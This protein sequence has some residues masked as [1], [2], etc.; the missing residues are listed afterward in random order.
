MLA[1]LINALSVVGKTFAKV[2]IALI[3][4]GAANFANYTLLKSAGVD[5][6]SI[7]A[8]DSKGTLHRDRKDIAARQQELC[9]KWQVCLESN[10][11]RIT[12]GTEDALR[13]TDIALAFSKPGPGIIR[14]EWVKGMNRQAI[15]FA[16]ANPTPEIW[17]DDAKAAGAR[18]VATGR[19]DFPNQ[20]NNG[21][22]FPGLFRGVL[23]VRAREIN[24]AMTI[25]VAQSLAAALP[26]HT[27]SADRILPRIDDEN[28]AIEVA[29]AAGLSAQ[30]AGLSRIA[31][32]ADELG[33][34]AREMIFGAR[35]STRLLVDSGLI[36]P[37]PAN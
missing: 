24:E 13:G 2:K 11:D 28:A 32:S 21:L 33:A 15:V 1:G 10:A 20:V 17:P 4:I 16:C 6:S 3:G 27:L 31:L 29:V 26:P 22:V 30:K 18:I 12:G 25:A 9:E 5:P 14:P 35:N 8:C 23:D 19:S 37:F 36:R 7:V 34:R